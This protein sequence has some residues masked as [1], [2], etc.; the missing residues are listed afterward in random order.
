ME[1]GSGKR[2]KLDSNLGPQVHEDSYSAHRQLQEEV[3]HCKLNQRSQPLTQQLEHKAALQKRLAHADHTLQRL[4]N[5]ASLVDSMIVQSLVT[6]IHR[7]V[8]SFLD[9]VL[10]RKNPGQVSLFQGELR[11]GASDQL[12]MFPPLHLFK[13]VLHGAVLSVA[14]SIMQVRA[15]ID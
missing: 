5:M 7:E 14:D 15:S 8:T 12:T 3:K 1:I 10:K 6:I 13:E 11:F 4:V 2:F 9:I